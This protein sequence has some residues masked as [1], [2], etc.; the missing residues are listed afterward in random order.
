MFIVVQSENLYC[1]YIYIYMLLQEVFTWGGAGIIGRSGGNHVPG[2]V[3]G[4]P[5]GETVIKV[6][7]RGE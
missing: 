1:L 2:H 5:S 6:S 7:P 4:I 3:R